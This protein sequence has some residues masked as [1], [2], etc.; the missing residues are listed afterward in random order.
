MFSKEA[1]ERHELKLKLNDKIKRNF[2]FSIKRWCSFRS[3]FDS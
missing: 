3:E 2:V 1:I